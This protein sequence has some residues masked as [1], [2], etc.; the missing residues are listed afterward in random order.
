MSEKK[1]SVGDW[2]G[3]GISVGEAR[4]SFG[5]VVPGSFDGHIRKSIP[6][7]EDGH[8]LTAKLSDFFVGPN[9]VVYDLGCSTG[10]LTRRLAE[11]HQDLRDAKFSG[12]EVEPEMLELARS[13]HAD[14]QNLRFEHCDILDYEFEKSDFIASHY[15]LQFIRL[16]DRMGL[17]RQIYNALNEGG[18]FVLFE[19]V[20]ASDAQFQDI[21]G[22][23][24][25]QFKLENGFTVDEIMAKTFSLKG[26]MQPI[27]TDQN[28][29]CLRNVGF[30]K[31]LTIQKYLCFEGWLAIK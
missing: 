8:E 29:I 5:G 14:V 1:K 16:K 25:N 13:R 2:V 30:S 11:R 31:I 10:T 6:M 27:S 23:L 21:M 19:K 4:W 24:Y 9:S 20:S 7:Y 22:L 28:L 17:L 3:D 26:V 15:T 18:A 12:L